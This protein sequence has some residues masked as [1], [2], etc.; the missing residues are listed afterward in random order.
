ML[1]FEPNLLNAWSGLLQIKA[2]AFSTMK[3]QIVITPRLWGH[4]GESCSLTTFLPIVDIM[5]RCKDMFC[6]S[7]KSVPKAFFAVSLWG[8]C[9][10]SLDHFFKWQS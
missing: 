1:Q 2:E 6:Q 5:F 10:G 9:P 3:S 7:S 4:V 8:K